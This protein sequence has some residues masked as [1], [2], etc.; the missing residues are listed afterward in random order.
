MIITL[1]GMTRDSTQ[2]DTDDTESQRSVNLLD[3]PDDALIVLLSF[4]DIQTHGRLAIVCQSL[5]RILHLECVWL[6]VKKYL[7]AVANYSN[8]NRY[9]STYVT[10][11]CTFSYLCSSCNTK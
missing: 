8:I 11:L 10:H 4:C 6:K 5:N 3:L 1:E 2:M 7:T 9:F